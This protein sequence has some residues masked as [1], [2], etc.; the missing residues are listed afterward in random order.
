MYFFKKELVLIHEYQADQEAIKHSTEEDYSDL[1][2][3][4]AQKSNLNGSIIHTFYFSPIK[5]RLMMVF[6]K[7]SKTQYLY[8]ALVPFLFAACTLLN[9]DNDKT[10][11]NDS[12]KQEQFDT[13]VKIPLPPIVKSDT[14]IT[15][16]NATMGY[17]P[18]LPSFP[19]GEKELM[20]FLGKNIQYPI[21]G[22]KSG[23]Q[24][25]SYIKFEVYEDGSIHNKTIL[26]SLGDEFDKE[27]FRV[28][29]LMPN[30]LPPTKDGK[31]VKTTY[32]LPVKFK[33]SD[34]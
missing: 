4:F 13:E 5:S 12:T 2:L 19:G 30:W 16:S 9:Q 26:R 10:A 1:L 22:K 6:K 18:F 32:T 29:D 14:T 33:L 23:I 31:K 8:L 11:A 15:N 34:D 25:T 27:L 20:E 17:S 24:G 28:V 7:S 21:N 3:Q